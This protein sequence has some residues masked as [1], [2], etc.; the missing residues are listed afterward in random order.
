MSLSMSVQGVSVLAGGLYS[1]AEL[2]GPGALLPHD[3]HCMQSTLISCSARRCS[4]GS[5]AG[6]CSTSSGS[7]L[8]VGGENLSC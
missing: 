6:D 8:Q 5:S 3:A 4:L 7:L 2:L 1:V